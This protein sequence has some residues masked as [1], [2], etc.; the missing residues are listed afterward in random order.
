MFYHLDTC[1]LPLNDDTVVWYPE[2]FAPED[3]NKL[4]DYFRKEGI[5][6]IAVSREDALQFACNAVVIGRNVVMNA[7]ISQDLHKALQR[8]GYTVIETPLD[9][10]L[11]GG[12]SAKCQ[13]LWLYYRSAP[14]GNADINKEED[15][16]LKAGLIIEGDLLPESILT[17]SLAMTGEGDV[18][19]LIG[20]VPQAR[21]AYLRQTINV[22][23]NPQLNILLKDREGNILFQV[24]LEK[25]P[26]DSSTLLLGQ[27]TYIYSDA[28]T[29]FYKTWLAY[30]LPRWAAERG[31]LRI[32][33]PHPSVR[34]TL[35]SS[36]QFEDAGFETRKG[37]GWLLPLNTSAMEE[38]LGQA[39]L[40][41]PAHTYF[42]GDTD[43]NPRTL[44]AL[45]LGTRTLN[46]DGEWV[47]QGVTVVHIGD[48]VGGPDSKAA[49]L[50]LE[51][52]QEKAAQEGGRLVRLIGNHEWAI[53]R[54]ATYTHAG[55][56]PAD[57]LQWLRQ[58]MRQDLKEGKIQVAFAS[59]GSLAVHAGIDAS[60]EAL[61]DK[62]VP[63][64]KK[65]NPDLWAA[66]VADIL[67]DAAQRI[68]EGQYVPE[69]IRSLV[70]DKDPEGR[71]LSVLSRVAV[72]NDKGLLKR[73]G[74]T[75]VV[76]HTI[77][78]ENGHV[79]QVRFLDADQ[80]VINVNI[81][82]SKAF[83]A[84]GGD[85]GYLR[86]TPEGQS[87]AVQV[88]ALTGHRMATPLIPLRVV[89]SDVPSNGQHGRNKVRANA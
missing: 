80:S 1:F 48:A 45:L 27:D 53:I 55:R 11:K 50:E 85:L 37:H 63:A 83:Q 41:I 12:G 29:S 52:L 24:H 28:L 13:V 61:L 23:G 38:R 10:F 36:E 16:D 84:H 65:E 62:Y 2:A 5:E 35:H 72:K 56:I 33:F 39:A 64:D 66:E 70:D 7:G 34:H 14:H 17:R 51:R 82:D 86:V 73:P 69:Y 6:A 9:Q 40:P 43:G 57:D 75:F 32:L 54:G 4:K 68:I 25:D 15:L 18:E 3:Q 47:G 78:E 76:G 21:Y 87:L 58:K 44:K 67:N 49:Y 89:P 77:E 8:Q 31:F 88:D 71:L 46:P 30:V 22:D 20:R 74:L 79:P 59:P 42:I 60:F 26:K 81:A 19:A